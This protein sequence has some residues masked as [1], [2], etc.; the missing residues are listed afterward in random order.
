MD[1]SPPTSNSNPNSNFDSI[2]VQKML[3]VYNAV[4]D[5][6]TVRKV[7]GSNRHQL[8]F[9]FTKDRQCVQKKILSDNFLE[10]F[11]TKHLNVNTLLQDNST[12][13]VA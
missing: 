11:A 10:H 13:T 1:S 7:P 12:H 2:Q 9:E 3:F 6:W 4:L 8:T 5:G